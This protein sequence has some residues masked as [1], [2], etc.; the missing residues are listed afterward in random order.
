[1]NK[2]LMFVLE[3]KCLKLKKKIKIQDDATDPIKKKIGSL[4]DTVFYS[5][6]NGD[7]YHLISDSA[8]KSFRDHDLSED[9]EAWNF[10]EDLLGTTTIIILFVTRRKITYVTIAVNTIARWLEKSLNI[11]YIVKY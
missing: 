7:G 1:M 8:C 2:E 10:E 5:C 4:K 6:D 3:A 11:P 9:D